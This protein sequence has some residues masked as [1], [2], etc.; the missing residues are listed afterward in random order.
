[1][2]LGLPKSTERKFTRLMLRALPV[3]P[4]PELYDIFIDLKEGKKSINQKIDKAYHSLKETSALIKDL[5]NDLIER[6][7]KIKELK[8]KYEDYSKLAEIEEEKIQ[9]LIKQ[10]D[11]AVGKGRIYE[12]IVSFLINIVAG[13]ILFVLGIWAGPKIQTYFDNDRYV[14]N[15]DKVLSENPTENED[16]IPNLVL[17]DSLRITSKLLVIDGSVEENL[18]YCSHGIKSY[19]EMDIYDCSFMI[20]SVEFNLR[21]KYL[22]DKNGDL[23][24]FW[25][26]KSE[27]PLIY[28]KKDLDTDERFFEYI[29]GVKLSVSLNG[30][31]IIDSKD[32]L[33]IE[34]ILEKQKL[35]FVS[36]RISDD[37]KIIRIIYE[38]E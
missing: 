10:L 5:E 16:L 13:I 18:N 30:N 37:G 32:T 36:P 17:S 29:G 2:K 1:M 28:S 22:F 25:S 15:N 34:K 38:Y 6:T 4:G 14:K 31:N 9:P 26:Y 24:S 33:L 19:S 23:E 7:D 20:D 35:I 21:S 8:E 11:K 3:L 27:G 12:R